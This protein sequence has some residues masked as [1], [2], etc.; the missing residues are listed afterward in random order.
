[1]KRTNFFI[2]LILAAMTLMLLSCEEEKDEIDALVGTYV[3][4]SATFNDTVTIIMQQAII[5]FLPGSDAA[6]FVGPGLLGAAP[7]DNPQ[8]AAIELKSDGTSYYTCLNETNQQQMGTWSINTERTVLTLNISYPQA[9]SL[10]ISELVITASSFSGTVEN[11]PLPL[12]A[13]FELGAPLPGG[14]VNYQTAS[15]DVTFT[16]VP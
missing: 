2:G 13:G 9:F 11:F 1:M 8:N 7:C 14:L 15:V 3:F 10:N 5:K 16:N 4:T 12:D 6:G